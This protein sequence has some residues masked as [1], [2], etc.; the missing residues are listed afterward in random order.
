MRAFKTSILSLLSGFF[1]FVM[2]L[3][4]VSS[5][6]NTDEFWSE[7]DGIK[8]RLDDL[9]D[10]LNGQIKAFND[11]MEDGSLTIRSLE[12]N[13]NTGAYI[14]TLSNGA[15][16][17]VLPAGLSP[18]GL[19]TYKEVEGVNCWATYDSSGALVLLE[20]KGGNFIPVSSVVPTVEERDG[21]FYLIVGDKEY[22]TGFSADSEV[23]VFTGYQL[24]TDDTG[25]TY[26]VTLSIGNEGM[27][28]TLPL[29][30]YLGFTFR[31]GT[32]NS[33]KIV[34]EYYVDYESTATLL[35]G[36][37]G[38]VDYV[39]Q[40][41][42]GWKVKE[43]V[44]ELEGETRLKITAPSKAAV[45]GGSAAGESDLKVIAVLEGGKAMA[46]RLHLTVNPFKRFTITST[47]AI[48]EITTGLDK[49]LYGIS[50]YP[51]DVDEVFAGADAMISANDKGISDKDINMTFQEIF[52]SE[53][54]T[55]KRYVLWAVPLF[56]D[57]DSE[58]SYFY[59]KDGVIHTL[60][61]GAT[62]VSLET[63]KVVF[64]GADIK[65]NIAG[66]DSFYAGTDE[67]ADD[68]ITN[69]LQQ[70]NAGAIEPY[71]TPMIYEGSAFMFPSAEANNSLKP[72][73]KG[74]Y[75][76]WIVPKIEGK[77]EYTVEDV[78]SKDYTLPGVEAG[79]A[80]EVTAGASVVDKVSIS[81]P[82]SSE[83]A[84]G[85]Y[86]IFLS[87]ASAKRL[88]KDADVVDYLVNYGKYV[89]GAEFTAVD[90]KVKPG[91]ERY[92]F[93]IAVDAEGKYGSKP[94]RVS[95]TTDAIVYNDLA[96][97]L[98]EA[99]VESNRASVSIAVSGGDAEELIWWYGKTSD[100]FWTSNEYCAK[101]LNQAQEYMACYPDDSNIVGSMYRA[102]FENGV[103][104]MR[105]LAIESDYVLVVMAKDSKGNY[106]V[107]AQRYFRTLAANLGVIVREGTTAWKDAKSQIKIEWDKKKFSMASEAGMYA[108]NIT[109]PSH[110][111]AY[112]LCISDMYFE[113]N[114]DIRKVED[115]IIDIE[116]QC[117]RKYDDGRTVIG[118]DGTHVS[119]PDWVDDAG[120]K[121]EGFLL[122][123]YDFYVHGFPTN[124]FATYFAEG[125]H[126]AG[127]CTSWE[128]GECYNY[129]YALKHIARRLSLDYYKDY[130]KS[131]RG[132]ACK[133]E[134]VINKC[135]Q[136]LFEAY[137]PYYKDAKPL[138]YI[139]D[140]SPLYMEQH[141]ASGPDDSGVVV[142]DVYVVL[143]D[144]SGNYYEPMSF[145]VPNY[146]K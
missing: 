119:E 126:G 18:K 80:L 37:D 98:G 32:A 77:D 105:D 71:T 108:F 107:A 92:L 27:K 109:I 4:A 102:V 28:I 58:D 24:N 36:L 78:I 39:M 64:N 60:D 96:V 142:D 67:Y 61:F 63:A 114:P 69:V 42:D 26:S 70:I 87:S 134:A 9:E 17:S 86:Y 40:V 2:S 140:G 15:T 138:I 97:T 104:E 90:A 81:V 11:L 43:V 88:T 10:K 41:P 122:N 124:G 74:R 38:V 128:D 136:D 133:T 49:F 101:D 99:T 25:N 12:K 56:Y 143:K 23:A 44:D 73:M 129:N 93:A 121:H 112:V 89:T 62:S 8:G 45:A 84:A 125:T 68:L 95:N 118:P 103:L 100:V 139:N 54:D 16:F 117:S 5:C 7:I 33:S 52:G 29:D 35:A 127:N 111:T 48:I 57:Y 135:A 53:L 83:G 31:I 137:Y 91:T 59:A 72:A 19:I 65:V 76:T 123:V 130:V 79:G 1:C 22:E 113:Q 132:S 144:K 6:V 75:V 146:F 94:L 55:D 120:E 141:Y 115:K 3:T 82:I 131:Q 14:V 50:E 85:M 20:D 106:S 110:L 13:G 66:V 145:P 51:L 116:A 21:K 46:A 47:N 30:G 34:T